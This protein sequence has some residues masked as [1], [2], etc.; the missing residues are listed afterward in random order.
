MVF[1]PGQIT[2]LLIQYGYYLI[3]PIMVV[4]GPIITVIAAFL[5]SLGYFN[6]FV[7]YALAVLGDFVGDSLYYFLGHWGRR[8]FIN[9]WGHYVGITKERIARL[10]KHFHRHS[11]KTLILGKLSQNFSGIFLVTA[12]IVKMPFWK[13]TWFNMLV[14][15]PRSF[16]LVLAGFYFGQ[17]YTRINRYLDYTTLIITAAAILLVAIYLIAKKVSKKYEGKV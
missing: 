14:T 2:L 5:A 3:F 10:E 12:G 6:V 4:E 17:A 15:V 11:G 9:R 13:F 16:V 1:S 8:G 7:V